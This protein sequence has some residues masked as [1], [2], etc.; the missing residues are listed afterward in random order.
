[1]ILYFLLFFVP[2]PS[3]YTRVSL[4]VHSSG[5]IQPPTPGREYW[6]RVAMLQIGFREEW[7]SKDEA[8][9][10]WEIREYHEW[11]RWIEY[12]REAYL[13]TRDCPPI[14][15][16]DLFCP[17]KDIW[18]MWEANRRFRNYIQELQNSHLWGQEEWNE[19]CDIIKEVDDMGRLW[20][21]PWHAGREDQT[22]LFR[23]RNLK[24]LLD[25]IGLE[26]YERGWLPPQTPEWAIRKWSPQFVPARP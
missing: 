26:N 11:S 19:L 2:A 3:D 17:Q 10:A 18:A 15:S 7:M 22:M 25:K 12:G 1:M 9:N 4:E 13:G 5:V 23:R 21:H 24:T 14:A 6:Q 8:Q 20:D 16:R